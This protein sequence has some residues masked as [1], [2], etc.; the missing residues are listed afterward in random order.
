MND[1]STHEANSPRLS[2]GDWNQVPSPR[3]AANKHD[4]S[5]IY[6]SVH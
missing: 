6:E 5:A 4:G 3:N 1:I 2:G